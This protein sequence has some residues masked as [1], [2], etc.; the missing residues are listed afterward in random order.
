MPQICIY[1]LGLCQIMSPLSPP[2]SESGGVMSPQVLWW[3]RPC[4]GL[5]TLLKCLLSLPMLPVD[6]GQAAGNL[7]TSDWP[8]MAVC[9]RCP[10]KA[11]KFGC[12]TLIRRQRDAGK[13]STALLV[14]A[15]LSRMDSLD[16]PTV[17]LLSQCFS[18]YLIN[19]YISNLPGDSSS[20]VDL[21]TSNPGHTVCMEWVG[22]P[23]GRWQRRRRSSGI[24]IYYVKSF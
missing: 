24:I 19:C 14:V 13:L 21:T 16:G 15:W 8:S 9:C 3:R 20:N 7:L 23:I 6:D 12:R 22:I 4:S 1:L 17:D 18:T 2:A 11:N 5:Q 10:R